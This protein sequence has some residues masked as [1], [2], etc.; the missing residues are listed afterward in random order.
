MEDQ[1]AHE[2]ITNLEVILAEHFDSHDQIEKSIAENTDLTKEIAV[3]TGE[4]VALVKGIKGFRALTLWAAPFIIAVM[5]AWA[6][7]KGHV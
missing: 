1:R 6:W 7:I 5:A 3:N 4:L 2:R